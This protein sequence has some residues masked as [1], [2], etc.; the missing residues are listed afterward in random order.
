M[1]TVTISTTQ[2]L[3]PGPLEGHGSIVSFLLIKTILL[4]HSYACLF[5]RTC[6]AILGCPY[7]DDQEAIEITCLISMIHLLVDFSDIEDEST[8]SPTKASNTQEIP[9]TSKLP[10]T[11]TEASHECPSAVLTLLSVI[12]SILA[13]I[14]IGLLTVL[15]LKRKI[16]FGK[17]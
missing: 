7:Q 5:I 12:I 17:S 15:Y 2:L 6:T 9:R 13:L 1:R 4:Y 16:L 11:H 3:A 10:I 8:T 14:I